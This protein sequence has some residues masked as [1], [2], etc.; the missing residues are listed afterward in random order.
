[1]PRKDSKSK[2]QDDCLRIQVATGNRILGKR[3]SSVVSIFFFF[4]EKKNFFLRN[5]LSIFWT[6]SNPKY[7]VILP[8]IIS[9]FLIIKYFFHLT[10]CFCHSKLFL[11]L[12]QTISKF[13]HSDQVTGML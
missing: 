13:Y 3:Y 9:V 11:C 1:M 8:T 2:S 7:H 4:F 10:I 5:W 6:M 12:Q